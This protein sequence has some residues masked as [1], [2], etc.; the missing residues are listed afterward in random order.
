MVNTSIAPIRSGAR[1]S[2]RG[3]DALHNA[4]PTI[5]NARADHGAMRVGVAGTPHAKT[6]RNVNAVSMMM[7]GVDLPNVLIFMSGTPAPLLALGQ[8]RI[9]MSGTFQEHDLDTLRRGA[10]QGPG[11]GIPQEREQRPDAS[12]GFGIAPRN[13]G[14]PAPC[15]H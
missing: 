11:G 3:L 9:R 14:T 6:V 12:P 2:T 13:I 7:A 1:L 8:Y 4:Q 15:P 10:A 5:R